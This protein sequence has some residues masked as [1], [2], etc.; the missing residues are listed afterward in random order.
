MPTP[1]PNPIPLFWR[2]DEG[3]CLDWTAATRHLATSDPDLGR[4]IE[5]A[6][7][8]RLEP[9]GSISPFHYLQRAIVY[10]QLSGKA[11]ATIFG[12]FRGIYRVK[13]PP[14]PAAVAETPVPVLRAAG[15]SHAKAMA[16]IDLARH[17]TQG[18]I[19]TRRELATLD[20]D[21][22]ID[23]LTRVRGVGRWTV[24]MLLIF[25]LGHP[26][27][28]P[29]GD[30]GIRKGFAMTFGMK[31]LPAPRT[32]KRRAERWRPYRSLACWYLWR[33]VD[34]PRERSGQA[35]QDD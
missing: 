11:A 3:P 28:L 25:Y 20:P 35:D 33:A 31:R 30:L 34:M 1:R 5:Q 15:L 18:T 12:R 8:P 29:L 16:I 19:P 21:A 17:A 7:P 4:L 14:S 32:M 27:I 13:R 6:G 24:E 23:R 2:D 26:D 22:I 9:P 10:Q